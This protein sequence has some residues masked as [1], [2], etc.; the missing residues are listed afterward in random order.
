MFY[1]GLVCRKNQGPTREH[2][3]LCIELGRILKMT[4]KPFFRNTC[5]V[6]LALAVTLSLPALNTADSAPKRKKKKGPTFNQSTVRGSTRMLKSDVRI[7]RDVLIHAKQIDRLVESNY[8][9]YS[10]KPNATTTDSQFVRRIYLDVTGSIP[11]LIQTVEFMRSRDPQKRAKL[12][13]ALLNSEGYNSNQYNYWAN[14]LRTQDRFGNQVSGKPYIDYVKES[15]AENKPYNEFVHEL[16][17][18]KGKVWENG[19][20]GYM[21]RDR[22]MPLDNMSNTVQIF[23][24]T[25]IGCAQCHDHPF[26]EW[27]QMQFYQMAAFTAGTS[28]N[29]NIPRK[30]RNEV[31]NL[32]K[33]L[34]NSDESSDRKLY[35]Q[36]RLV[37]RANSTIVNDNDKRTLRL[38]HDYAYED[39]KP[40]STVK[41]KVLFGK[42]KEVKGKTRREV[43][44]DWLTDPE[45]PRFTKSIANRCWK[46]AFG[47]AQIE[48]IDNMDS[49]EPENPELMAYLTK[50]MKEMKYDLKAVMNVLYNTDAYQRQV[51]HEDHD[52]ELAYHFP[53][54]M[55]RRMTA[56]QIWDSMLTLSINNPEL[57]KKKELNKYDEMINMD[58]VS[59]TTDD[60]KARAAMITEAEDAFKKENRYPTYRYKNL[61]LLRASE[62]QSPLRNDH[63]LRRFGQS[64]R[65]LIED[66]GDTGSV[67][68]VMTML[69][70]PITHMMLEGGSVMYNS[71]TAKRNIND[72]IDVIFLSILSRKPTAHE[73]KMAIEEVKSNQNAGIG[74]VIWALVNTREFLFVQ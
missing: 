25:S 42:F 5:L 62:L 69:N 11:T 68:Q 55:L 52:L 36:V 49:A 47:I 9:K 26:E 24:G 2:A 57:Q 44:A 35:R 17:S 60:V 21:L 13:Q 46:K 63:F 12:I 67:P 3:V 41:P 23:L 73:R 37:N 18:A 51:A 6:L 28:T 74:N 15:I 64:D 31:R 20:A 7:D 45:N 4:L 33:E 22:G 10:V 61:E 39:A 59:A 43:F 34:R 29:G 14:I 40:K 1:V 8:R 27:T 53:G 30:M 32:E 70:G 65:E 16:L 72:K 66:S 56:E 38:P 54:P 71:V 50:M 19:A 58:F 48:P